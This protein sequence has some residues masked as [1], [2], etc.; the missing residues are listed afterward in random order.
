MKE[1]FDFRCASERN[2]FDTNSNSSL[3]SAITQKWECSLPKQ[4]VSL[5]ITCYYHTHSVDFNQSCSY[6]Y[7]HY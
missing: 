3:G 4:G 7:Y 5:M 1:K 2:N 6:Y